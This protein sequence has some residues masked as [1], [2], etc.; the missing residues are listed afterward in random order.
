MA[1]AA[2][3][4]RRY[5]PICRL[6]WTSGCCYRKPG[7]SSQRC[8]G[9]LL[10]CPALRP[11]WLVRTHRMESQRIGRPGCCPGTARR[12]DRCSAAFRLPTGGGGASGHLWLAGASSGTGRR[13]AGDC[14]GWT[15]AGSRAFGDVVYGGHP[16][17]HCR[18]CLSLLNGPSAPDR[19]FLVSAGRPCGRELGSHRA[20]TGNRRARRGDGARCGGL[21]RQKASGDAGQWDVLCSRNRLLRGMA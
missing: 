20:G 9:P 18:D 17:L 21:A 6:A 5:R 15:D 12:I 11:E 10:D 2:P 4:G 3:R 8:M 19:K 13:L 16:C 14:S 1:P 7:H